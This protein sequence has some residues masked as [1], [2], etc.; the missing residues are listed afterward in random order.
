MLAAQGLIDVVMI[1]NHLVV[2]IIGGGVTFAS[3]LNLDGHRD[4][5]Q[6]AE[7]RGAPTRHR[8]FPESKVGAD[9][10]PDGKEGLRNV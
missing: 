3:R 6:A 8:T 7:A 5:R 9:R 4:H 2:A 1:S 10:F